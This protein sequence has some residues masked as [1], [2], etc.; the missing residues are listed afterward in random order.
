MGLPCLKKFYLHFKLNTMKKY[1]LFLSVIALF[2]NNQVVAQITVTSTNMPGSGDT[3]RYSGCRA[4]SV[5]Y[6]TTGANVYWNY[7]TLQPQSQGMYN[8]L[9]ASQT[10]Y[11]FYFTGA[12]KYGLKIADSIGTGTFTFKEVYDFYKKTTAV[13]ETEG[14]GFKYSGIPLAAMY[15]DP[16]EIYSFPL[17]YLKHDSTTYKVTVQLGTTIYYSQLGYRINDVD[18]WG[19]IKTPYDSVPCLRLV[20]TTYGKDSINYNGIG[21]TFPD[22]QRTY[23]WISLTEKIPML[24]LDGNYTNN[25]FTPTQARYRDRI[26]SFAGIESIKNAGYKVNVYPNP[27]AGDLSFYTNNPE[28]ATINLFSAAGVLMAS[29]KTTGLITTVSTQNLAKGLYYYTISTKQMK[30]AANGKIIIVN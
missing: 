27:S 19:I 13:F 21:F 14:L 20:S 4:N 6:S 18:G 22:V 23:K 2:L 3:L 30:Q 24:E 29:Y 16:D 25:N 26:Q 7:D 5:N 11:S 17:T 10:P 1:I 12:G 15:S 28:T 9:A 8:Y